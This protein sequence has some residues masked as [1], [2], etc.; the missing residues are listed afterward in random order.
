MKTATER[1]W[2]SLSWPNRISLLRLLLVAP[3][4]VLLLSQGDD[5]WPWARH[6]AIAIFVVMAVSDM[7]DGILARRL[8]QKTRLGAI[9]DPL[10]DKILIISSVL[11]LSQPA[12]AVP[13]AMLP[14]WVVVA[15]VGKDLWI[16]I[17]FL[18][19]YLVT[20][21]LRAEPSISGK[22]STMAQLLMVGFV[23]VAPELDAA[24]PGLALGKWIVR[25]LMYA[26][27]VLAALAVISYTRKGLRTIAQHQK[28]LENHRATHDQPHAPD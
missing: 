5:G 22:A 27:A 28:P 10:A 12:K 3:F 16:V 11:V 25:V 20:D 18:V 17:G 15:V 6:V 7:V 14:N 8:Q 23:L 1:P 21:K 9:L 19:V 2:G 26:V 24:A 13:D 4:I